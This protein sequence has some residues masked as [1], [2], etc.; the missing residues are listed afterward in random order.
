M[1]PQEIFAARVPRYTSYP[2]APHFH[3][4]IDAGTYRA[5]LAEL[6]PAVALSLYVHIPFCDTLCWF[7]GCHAKV[8]NT[9][10]PLAGYLDVLDREIALTAA[11]LGAR[12]RVTHIHWGGGSPTMLKPDDMRRLGAML[13]ARFDIAPDAEF[14]VEIDPRGFTAETAKALADIGVNRA[15]VGVQDFTPEVQRAINRLQD[16]ETTVN[17]IGLLRANGISRLNVD[18]IYGLPHQT[19]EGLR[20]TIGDVLSL[21]PDRL[22]IFGYAHVPSFK[23]HQSLIPESALP[24]L[25][26]RFAQAEAARRAVVAAG[27]AAIGLDHFALTDDP[28]ATAVASGTLRRNFQGYTTDVAPALIGLGASAISS[29]PQGY[30]QNIVEVPQWRAAI[31]EGRLPAA[32]GIALSD[33]DRIRRAV[34]E[35]LMSGLAVDL[36]AV[37]REYGAD[38]KMFAVALAALQPYARD[39]IVCIDGWRLAVPGRWRSAVRLVCAAFDSYLEAGAARHSAAV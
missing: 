7:C 36:A 21:Q 22:A 20:R 23:K 9:Y 14:A 24:G 18:L 19:V 38:P 11:A 34:I 35:R 17:C 8:V 32:R 25:E 5:W 12:R 6:D 29:L 3:D 1:N 2:T 27:Y 33:D 13:R 16:F 28:M 4:G 15:S 39:G 26:A 10:S 31:A 30:V 37:A